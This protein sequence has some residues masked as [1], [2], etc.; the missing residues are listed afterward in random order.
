M[1]RKEVLAWINSTCQL[2][3]TKVEDTAS[4]A[5]ACLLLDMLYPGQVPL[6][7]VNWS[8]NKSFE[9]VSNYKILQNAFTK[10]KIDR[11]I[12]VDRLISGRAMDNLEF[13]QWFKRYFELEIGSRPAG[14]DTVAA[15]QKGK[16]GSSYK[17]A[18][19]AGAGAGGS[20]VEAKAKQ[21]TRSTTAPEQKKT[22]T[23][24][25]PARGGAAKPTTAPA[26]TA[27]EVA[28]LTKENTDMKLEMHGL[29]K[30]RD[31]YFNKLRD[32]EIM[33]QDIE[34]AGNG[35]PDSL[36]KDIF[37]ILYATADGFVQ[38]PSAVSV[39]SAALSPTPSKGGPPGS[40]VKSPS[41]V[42]NV[43]MFGGGPAM[44]II[45]N[46]GMIGSD[47][48][49]LS[50]SMGGT[51]PLSPLR[52]RSQAVEPR[53]GSPDRS[54]IKSPA[55]SP[56]PEWNNSVDTFPLSDAV[57]GNQDGDAGSD[58]DGDEDMVSPGQVQN[59]FTV[60]PPQDD[61]DGR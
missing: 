33:L 28:A 46:E 38:S 36:T 58:E 6:A 13:M 24:I 54:P 49:H 56:K 2:N 45:E 27:S 35:T 18:Q 43:A 26:A 16:G 22:T 60:P 17:G 30:E 9:Y 15:R 57:V 12:D 10:L 61:D 23:S 41:R 40:A 42:D 53:Q 47:A 14:Y 20:T 37:T 1:G 21:P 5:V 31:F 59:P 4:G 50:V 44:D 55:K 34:D 25:R 29:E 32:I 39:A 51:A 3:I 19:G 48:N 8:A 7:R 11:H 52:H